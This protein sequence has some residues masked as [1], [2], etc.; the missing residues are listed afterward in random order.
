MPDFG[1]PGTVIN[2]EGPIIKIP[3]LAELVA[4]MHKPTKPLVCV[5][6]ELP[7]KEDETPSDV[8]TAH[9]AS[10]YQWSELETKWKA[11]LSKSGILVNL[12]VLGIE[13]EIQEKKYDGIA[14]GNTVIG[15]S[16]PYFFTYVAIQLLGTI[17]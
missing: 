10:A 15:V 5:E 17:K 9:V 2:I 13:A 3:S 6:R 16:T 7:D 1:I 14:L 8:I 11:K 4:D 12:V